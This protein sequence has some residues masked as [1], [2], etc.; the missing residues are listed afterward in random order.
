M[1]DNE[2]DIF[3]IPEKPKKKRVMREEQKEIL[4][5]RLKAAREAKKNKRNL[6]KKPKDDI[7]S[8]DTPQETTDDETTIDIE[9]PKENNDMQSNDNIQSISL[10]D[11]DETEKDILNLQLDIEELTQKVKTKKRK[12]NNTRG[13]VINNRKKNIEDEINK[14]VNERMNDFKKARE[15]E[16]KVQKSQP[17]PQQNKKIEPPKIVKKIAPVGMKKPFWAL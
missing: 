1:S 12:N 6:K 15:I 3:D 4:R 10:N 2:N 14:R 8:I 9:P 7:Q 13:M 11:I 16:Q 5:E 17:S